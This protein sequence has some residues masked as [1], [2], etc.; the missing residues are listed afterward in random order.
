MLDVL[1]RA[2]YLGGWIVLALAAGAILYWGLVYESRAPLLR[3][4]VVEGRELEATL[5]DSLEQVVARDTDHRVE[6][7]RTSGPGE[8]RKLVQEGKL[9]IGVF[10]AAG[11]HVDGLSAVMPL[12]NRYVQVLAA[13]DAAIETVRDLRGKRVWVGPEQ[14]SARQHA[15]R[16]MDFYGIDE[17]EIDPRGG[18][19]ASTVRAQ[20]V[21]AALVARSPRDP[22]LRRVMGS[23]AFRGLADSRFEGFAYNHPGYTHSAVP[24][25]A[26]P[27]AQGPRPQSSH[28]VPA[29]LAVFATRPGFPRESVEALLRAASAS[30]LRHDLPY[31]GGAGADI[32]AT[33][34]SELTHHPAVDGLFGGSSPGINRAPVSRAFWN[35]LGWWIALAVIVAA[36]LVHWRRHYLE[37]RRRE[38]TST[39]REIE[40]QFE[41]LVEIERGVREARDARVLNDKLRELNETK[42][43][44]LKVALGSEIVESGLF[45]AFLEQARSVGAEI[46]WRM[47]LASGEGRHRTGA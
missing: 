4:G 42:A 34:W 16:I 14:S 36:A 32:D 31:V 27:T 18:A 28:V 35:H 30:E 2:R 8:T 7:R 23:G 15:N 13:E 3:V 38:T 5:V 45:L 40:R 25:G 39:R 17:D 10:D 44:V 33:A 21:D 29:A 12:W 41:A 47:S 9:D 19:L 46:E 22:S 24:A 11:P 43:K 6:L 26:Y 37:R 1:Y 20:N